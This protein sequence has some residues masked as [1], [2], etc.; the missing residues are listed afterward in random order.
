MGTRIVSEPYSD[1][2]LTL[3]L[4]FPSPFLAP[5]SSC[6]LPSF[7]PGNDDDDVD[8]DDDDDDV[9]FS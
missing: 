4:P 5:F 8:D 9:C 6:D 7:L 1:P 3:S 2:I